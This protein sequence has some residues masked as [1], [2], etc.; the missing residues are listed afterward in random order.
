ML[1]IKSGY[2][3]LKL[4]NGQSKSFDFV[5]S[6]F[7]GKFNLN[8]MHVYS[9]DPSTGC[10]STSIVCSH[11]HDLHA[12]DNLIKP[13]ALII[14][15][16]GCQFDVKALKAFELGASMLIIH[17]KTGS[18]LQRIGAHDASIGRIPIPAII[19][20]SFAGDELKQMNKNNDLTLSIVPSTDNI[21]YKTWTDLAF[22]SFSDVLDEM[23]LQLESLI[24]KYVDVQS[25]DIVPWIRKKIDDAKLL[26]FKNIETDEL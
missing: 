4:N 21:L 13:Y 5:S 19:I 24:E 9:V 10:Q 22:Y 14:D 15:R 8:S 18:A 11:D 3:K 7:G 16:G 12:C 17:D 20:T 25:F 23:I 26:K 6:N 1:E 2:V